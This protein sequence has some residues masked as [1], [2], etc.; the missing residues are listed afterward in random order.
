MGHDQSDDIFITT[1]SGEPKT[2]EELN[3]LAAKLALDRPKTDLIMDLGAVGEPSYQT[4]CKLMTLC[5]FLSDLGCSCIFYNLSAATRRVFHLYGFD[6]IF[7]ITEVSE[8][9][10]TPSPKQLDN[11]TLEIRGLNNAKPIERRKYV[12]LRIPSWLQVN[13]L[14]WHGGRNDDYHKLIPGHFWHGRLV[15]ISEGGIQVAIDAAE[16]T[17]LDKG[18]LIGLEFRPIPAEP[19]L[20][21]DAKIREV[22]PTADGKNICLGLQFIGLEANPE[23]RQG[24]RKLCV[25]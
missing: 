13:V 18:Q 16:R 10:F 23:G 2:S 9:V 15:D 12:R 8:I 19:L 25:K 7:Q 3:A 11:G 17:H 4:L 22:L 5:S 20:I 6:R 14:F 24:L 1:L 21:F